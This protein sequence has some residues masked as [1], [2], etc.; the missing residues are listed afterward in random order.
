MNPLLQLC[1]AA[2]LPVAH[3]AILDDAN[4]SARHVLWIAAD[5]DGFDLGRQLRQA[6]KIDALAR[7][8]VVDADPLPFD[9]K[10]IP[11]NLNGGVDVRESYPSGKAS[12]ELLDFG[13]VDQVVAAA[14]FAA[15]PHGIVT[16]RERHLSTW[17]TSPMS[18]KTAWN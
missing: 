14:F 12:C 10:E 3:L 18:E 7:G 16:S 17:T 2:N 9:K 4:C 15:P 5:D 1:E 13:P 6:L 11:A 8:Y